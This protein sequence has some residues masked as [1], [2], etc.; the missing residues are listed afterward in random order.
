MRYVCIYTSTDLHISLSIQYNTNIIKKNVQDYMC[1]FI[2]RPL[3]Q[4]Q[5]SLHHGTAQSGVHPAGQRPMTS[6][7]CWSELPRSL[8][9]LPP[10]PRRDPPPAP[11]YTQEPGHLPPLGSSLGNIE[12]HTVNYIIKVLPFQTSLPNVGDHEVHDKQGDHANGLNAMEWIS[13]ETK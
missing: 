10:P 4:A 6:V 5:Q 1:V 8:W 2:M 9:D 11:S 3:V 13:G 12:E 7:N